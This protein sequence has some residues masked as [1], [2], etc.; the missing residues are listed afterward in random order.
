L[1]SVTS[2]FLNKFQLK[3]TDI[4]LLIAGIDGTPATKE[5]LKLMN[6]KFETSTIAGFK[7]LSGNFGTDSTFAFWMANNAVLNA[8]VGE[9][10]CLRGEAK[11]SFEKVMVINSAGNNSWSFM[12]LSKC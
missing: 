8:N 1:E 10:A 9:S 4:D 6:S 7:H 2:D 5:L 11:R 12:L 3:D